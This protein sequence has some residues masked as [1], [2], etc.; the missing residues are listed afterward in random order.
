ML[1][2]REAGLG[3][4]A[5][6]FAGLAL[7]GC[8][9]LGEL[10]KLMPDFGTGPMRPGEGYGGLKADRNR[11]PLL[12]LPDGF[13]Y[14]I[15]SRATLEM[16]NDGLVV[17][18]SFDGMGAFELDRERTI[19]VRNHEL[20]A[21]AFDKSAFVR[22]VPP[23][24][25]RYLPKNGTPLPG[26]TTTLVYN[27][28]SGSVEHQY[29]SLAGTQR[30]CSGGVTPWGTWLT[31]EEMGESERDHGWVFEVPA[32]QE[33]L[34]D[35]VPLRGL[36]Q[37][38]HEAAAVSPTTGIVYLTEDQ[39]DGLFYRFIPDNPNHLGAGGKLQA[40]AF[41]GDHPNDARNWGTPDFPPGPTNAREVRWVE[42][43]P[44]EAEARSQP[45]RRLGARQKAVRFAASE[46]IYFGQNEHGDEELFFCCTSG[47]PGAN[48]Q[49]MRYRP[50]R[51][52]GCQ[53]EGTSGSLELFLE[54][55]DPWAFKHCDN[56]TMAPNG[57]LIICEESY[58]LVGG[59]R[60]WSHLRGVTPSGGVYDLARSRTSSELA[61]A[62]FAPDGKTMFVNVYDPGITLAITGPW[63]PRRAGWCVPK[64][65]RL[66]GR[67]D[68]ALGNRCAG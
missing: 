47:G 30:N 60:E 27:Q 37:F 22:G 14:K 41:A 6:A 68:P 9:R 55:T 67:P 48:G 58:V 64:A 31:C 43:S 66:P 19:L 28:T 44:A 5:A 34:S 21:A 12:D 17:P 56:L 1:N 57:D 13:E 62:C 7:G 16:G 65:G 46:G 23:G 53:S 32:I 61:G 49:I 36:G 54:S 51:R 35:P 15:I 40:L 2:R 3:I 20:D 18:G 42:F 52:E 4:T 8:A 50:S 63:K 59:R 38:K 24:Q 39:I 11:T 26:G 45:L 25:K 29:L 33:E 10:R